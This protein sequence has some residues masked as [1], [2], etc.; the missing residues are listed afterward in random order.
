M[1]KTTK[2]TQTRRAKSRSDAGQSPG[3]PRMVPSRFLLELT[4]ASSGDVR[5]SDHAARSMI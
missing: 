4:G 3:S 5:L 1:T 2:K